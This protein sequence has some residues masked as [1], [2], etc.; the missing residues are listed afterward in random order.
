[1]EGSLQ[2]P[3]LH[4]VI[5]PLIRVLDWWFGGLRGGFPSTLAKT[6]EIRGFA[7]RVVECRFPGFLAWGRMGESVDPGAESVSSLA[8]K[9]GEDPNL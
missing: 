4:K 7:W 5:F 8:S 3:R 2:I 1:M 6:K 9:V